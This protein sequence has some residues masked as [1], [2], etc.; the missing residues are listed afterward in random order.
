MV[1]V[2]SSPHRNNTPINAK[3]NDR[4]SQILP[5]IIA[6][7]SESKVSDTDTD[8]SQDSEV[9][10]SESEVDINEVPRPYVGGKDIARLN[11]RPQ[12]SGKVPRKS[13]VAAAATVKSSTKTTK[14]SSKAPTATISKP[15]RYRPGTVA[16]REIRKY[17]SGQKEGT[18]LLIRKLPFQRLVREI[19]TNFKS[20]LRFQS[21]AIEALQEA[22]EAYL[23]SLFEDTLLCSIHAKRVTIMV[24]DMQLARRLRRE[25]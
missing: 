10:M 5:D 7:L 24:Q 1:K 2:K 21:S 3:I 25:L 20:D 9:E 6:Q 11:I 8:A 4:I 15:R 16:L 12:F 17:Q 14:I 23:V 13:L 22:S 18:R 19:A